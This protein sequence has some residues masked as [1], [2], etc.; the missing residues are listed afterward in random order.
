VDALAHF[1]CCF[2]GKR[3]R[4]DALGVYARFNKVQNAVC[5]D[6]RF[7]GTSTRKH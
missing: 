5:Y 1:F 2:V 3:D 6:A 7:S 4:E